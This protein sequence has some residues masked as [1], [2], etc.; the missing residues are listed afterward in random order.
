[1]PTL[2]F[3]FQTEYLLYSGTV[4]SGWG[5]IRNCPRYRN[6]RTKPWP[7]ARASAFSVSL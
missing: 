7:T 3:R 5:Q 4:T 2:R 6:W 1:L